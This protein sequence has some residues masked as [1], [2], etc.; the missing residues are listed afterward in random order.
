[1]RGVFVGRK[2]VKNRV[3]LPK[4]VEVDRPVPRIGKRVLI[5][6]LATALGA[7]CGALAGF[8][9]GRIL[10]IHHTHLHLKPYCDR[11]LRE[12]EISAVEARSVLAQIN[13]SPY[14]FCS[15]QEVAWIRTRIFQSEYLK[16]GGRIRGGRIQC[17]A[18]LGRV[19]KPLAEAVPDFTQPSGIRLY[20]NL[21]PFLIPGKTVITVQLGESFVV[22]SP[23]NLKDL[24]AAPMHFTVTEQ[25]TLSQRSGLLVGEQSTASES[26]LLKEG[27]RRQDGQTYFTEC[28][29]RFNACFTTYI[30]DREVLE[31]NRAEF[32]AYILL[33]SLSGGLLG[34][35]FS[36]LYRLRRS[37]AYQLRRSIA[38]N[39]LGVVYQPIVDLATGRIVGAEAL[40]R[41]T[42]D[43]GRKVSPEVFVRIAEE[44]GF[45]GELTALV[46]RRA[47]S[48]F[49]GTLA[50]RR[51]FN[52]SINVTAAD[53]ADDKFL[54]MLEDAVRQNKVK[55][56]SV[57]LELTEGSTARHTLAYDAIQDLRQMGHRIHIDDFGTGYSSLSYL[58]SLSI[59]AIKID[60]SFTRSIGTYSVT[61]GILP[62]I[63]AM[64][65]TLKLAVIVEGIET[66]EQA[67]YFG[68]MEQKILAQGWFFGYPMPAAEFYK[69]LAEDEK[70][71]TPPATVE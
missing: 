37:L 33:G 14:A 48:D 17:S 27:G 54:P 52:I 59:D 62:Q 21:T 60:K 8:I 42:D 64:A 51:D 35:A 71:E 43:E 20:R 38:H 23:W 36:L 9:L 22:Y 5:T 50:R 57:T 4:P 41:W 31:W 25:D 10:T 68:L 56:Q 45:V 34:F 15:D 55:A 28:S 44:R 30:S 12:G 58:N 70:K 32:T 19:E 67:K 3:K 18:T 26:V 6:V 46:V 65:E 40:V 16:E 61:V 63:L 13:A 69:L 66:A 39:A 2:S 11:V 29:S 53:L 47:L 24:G 1:M 49:A 7:G